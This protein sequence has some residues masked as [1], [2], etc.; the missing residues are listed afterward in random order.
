LDMPGSK[1]MFVKILKIYFKKRQ[2]L[3]EVPTF[4]SL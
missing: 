2:N 1:I 3:A 4:S